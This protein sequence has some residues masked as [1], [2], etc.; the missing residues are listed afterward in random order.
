MEKRFYI[1]VGEASGDLHASNL[2]REIKKADKSIVFRGF[3]GD[4]M[5]QAGAQI[6]R[7]Y[8]ELAFMGFWEVLTNLHTI[9][10][11]LRYCKED[12]A[13][14]RPHA[15]I[16]VD[17]PGFNMRMAR[18]LRKMRIPCFYYI[19][20]KVWA[21]NISRVKKIKEWVDH[22]FVILPFE[23]DFYQKYGYR[24]DF[25]GHPLLDALSAYTQNENFFIQNNLEQKRIIA[26]L[27]G[28][29]RQEIQRMLPV[30][31]RMVHH[32]PGYQ[33]V[34]AGLSHIG[35]PFYQSYIHHPNVKLVI[36]QT[37]DLLSHSFAA[38]VTSGT[39]T[40]E[41]A[42]FDVPQVVCYCANFISYVIGYFVI[43]VQFISLVNLICGKQVVTELIQYDLNE[44]NLRK[45]LQAILEN[46]TRERIFADY[47]LLR[48]KLGQPGASQRAA[49]LI[50]HYFNQLP[51][52]D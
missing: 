23:K 49:S 33:F 43:Q 26:L 24:V 29:R 47:R 51:Q 41:T 48:E 34:V 4:K 45:A 6:V 20:P 32:F 17:Y 13:A 1:I 36:D 28:S 12:I 35:A 39:A 8:R 9:S 3:G 18:Y 15:V 46:K 37:Y 52:R 38:L 31:L 10:R 30:M 40:L 50:L 21:W 16:L 14:F 19:S 25:V 2:I 7:H 5:Q 42:L 22:M 11:N 27:P 44:S